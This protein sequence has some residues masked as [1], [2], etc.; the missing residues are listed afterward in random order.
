[1]WT[2]VWV[3]FSAWWLGREPTPVVYLHRGPDGTEVRTAA[4]EVSGEHGVVIWWLHY[5]ATGDVD[6]IA[7]TSR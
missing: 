4:L 3:P 1:M 6:L 2:R 5:Y 7:I